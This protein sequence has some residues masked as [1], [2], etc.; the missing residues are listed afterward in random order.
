MRYAHEVYPSASKRSAMY[1]MADGWPSM[2]SS[3]ASTYEQDQMLQLVQRSHTDARRH[4]DSLPRYQCSPSVHATRATQSAHC[5]RPVPAATTYRARTFSS[6][7]HGT[8]WLS[9]SACS[10]SRNTCRT[11]AVPCAGPHNSS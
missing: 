10:S 6:S 11:S 9:L 2:R 5:A 4:S 7:T 3:S 8:P 1:C